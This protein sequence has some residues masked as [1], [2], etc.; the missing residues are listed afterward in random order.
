MRQPPPQQCAHVLCG[1]RVH[2][3]DPA[4]CPSALKPL[5]HAPDESSG[6]QPVLR[7]AL[8]APRAALE[9]SSKA[10]YVTG[11]PSQSAQSYLLGDGYITLPYA[12]RSFGLTCNRVGNSV[13]GDNT[14]G[15]C[16]QRCT[17]SLLVSLNSIHCST[18]RRFHAPL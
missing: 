14:R 11:L 3:P 10:R 18:C 16:F 2:L 4:D 17:P 9:Q 15:C 6:P 8:A 5:Q 7:S 13:P 1:I 12:W